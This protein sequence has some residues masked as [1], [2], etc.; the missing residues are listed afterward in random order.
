MGFALALYTK[1]QLG[2]TVG[3]ALQE[4]REENTRFNILRVCTS[5]II[6]YD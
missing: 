2:K 1:L 5:V 4:L 3:K 6:G